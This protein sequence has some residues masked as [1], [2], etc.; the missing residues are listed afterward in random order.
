MFK[1]ALLTMGLAALLA[2]QVNAQ[3]IAFGPQIGYQKAKDADQGNL[4]GGAALRF[5]LGPALGVEA[6]INYRQ[7]KF[8]ND[9]LTVR[10]WPVMATGLI[11]PLPMVYGAVGFGWYNTTFDFD[12]SKTPF[13]AVEDETNQKVGWH[14][15]AGLELPVGAKSKFTADIRYVFLD[16]KFEQ[17]PGAGDL[18]GDFYVI[19]A[20]LLFGL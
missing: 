7:E 2:T 19:T 1:K 13:Q 18:N 11:Y 6:S 8:A 4:M 17:V 20:G 10:S 5:K 12:Q 9:A 14:F 16:Y 15:G 3:G